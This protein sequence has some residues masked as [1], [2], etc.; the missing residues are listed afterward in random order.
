MSTKRSRS[1]P[2]LR[3]KKLTPEAILPTRGSM[4]AAGLDLSA[5]YDAVIPAGGKGLVKTDLVIAVPDGCYA[6]VAPR[7]GLALKKFI[8]TGAGVI[9]ADYRGNVGVILFN[10]AAEDFPVKRGDR[11]AQ[12][13]LEKIEYPEIQ[14]VDEIEDTARGAGGFG[15]TGV[16]LPIAK[17]QHVASNGVEESDDE[18]DV[19][20]KALEL[21]SEKK[22]VDDKTRAQ[23]KKKLV[24]A[25][26][27]QFKLLNKALDDYL[28]DEDSAKVLEWI[29]AFLESN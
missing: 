5:A 14:E 4:L 7:S 24:T 9:D 28:I 20:F 18:F 13:I 12:L 2:V 16:D 6:R 21:L 1:A 25:S 27:R 29:N 3:V 17:K 11:V 8:D 19:A 22:V 23:L 15:S 10:H 26:E